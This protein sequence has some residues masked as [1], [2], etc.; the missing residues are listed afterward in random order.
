MDRATLTAY[1]SAAAAFAQDW[2]EQPPP[3]DLHDLIRR[4][5]VPGRTVDI[6]CGSGREVAWLSS[7][8]FPAEGFDASEG[9]LAEARRRYPALAFGHAELPDLV[10]IGPES[11]DNVLCETVI[12]HLPHEAVAPAVRRLFEIVRPGGVLYLSWRVTANDDLRD[13]QGRLYAAF[14]AALVRDEL[15]AAERTLD[16]EVVSA[17]SGKVIHRIVARRRR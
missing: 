8:G 12:M 13:S 1:D 6:G 16:E 3:T 10:G 17:S 7:N 15:A 14:D 5:F 9:L 4:F 2:H 11:F